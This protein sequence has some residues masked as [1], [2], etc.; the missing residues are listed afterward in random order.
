M[1]QRNS[2]E[3]EAR[4]KISAHTSLHIAMISSHCIGG[5]RRRAVSPPSPINKYDLPLRYRP[6]VKPFCMNSCHVCAG[7]AR[8]HSHTRNSEPIRGI[9]V[10]CVCGQLHI[11][12]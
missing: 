9:G 11:P 7:K 1:L 2:D 12:G 5:P 4:G 8:D 3:S 10:E 6:E